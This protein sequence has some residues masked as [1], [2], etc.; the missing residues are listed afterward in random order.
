MKSKLTI[1]KL[2]P[3]P[4]SFPSF[5][6][7]GKTQKKNDSLRR[8]AHIFA[9]YAMTLHFP[10]DKTGTTAPELNWD[11]FV[12]YVSDLRANGT[13][14]SRT[15]L[16]WITVLA[17][18]FAPDV[19]DK[20]VV[21]EYRAR[22]RD[23]W[24]TAHFDPECLF[25]RPMKKKG[26]DDD[27]GNGGLSAG[28]LEAAQKAISEILSKH[29]SMNKL[30]LTL[31]K[32]TAEFCQKSELGV[33]AL[34]RDTASASRA[35]AFQAGSA[36]SIVDTHTMTDL[37]GIMRKLLESKAPEITPPQ[38]AAPQALGDDRNDGG[39]PRSKAESLNEGQAV[40]YEIAVEAIDAVVVWIEKG[41]RGYRPEAK[42]IFVHGGPGAG[43]SFL[44]S[45]ID[46]YAQSRG[47]HHTKMA[48]MASAANII[49]GR[50]IHSCAG[51]GIGKST[52]EN[53]ER[54]W[55]PL[56]ELNKTGTIW[57]LILDELS[58]L[59]AIMFYDA[60]MSYRKIMKC[61]R[62]FGGLSLFFIGDFFQIPPTGN[63][64]LTLFDAVIKVEV[65]GDVTKDKRVNHTARIFKNFRKVDLDGNERA[66]EDPAWA[67]L[68]MSLR[69]PT[70]GASPLGDYLIPIIDS[71]VLTSKDIEN[72]VKWAS[73]PICVCGNR[74]RMAL[75]KTRAR[76][77]AK[78][79][80][81]PLIRWRLRLTGSQVESLSTEEHEGIF[82]EDPCSWGFFIQGYA[83][84]F[85][86]KCQAR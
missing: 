37:K 41:M 7:S 68:I 57:G 65:H 12:T 21:M 54:D 3:S 50:T 36:P 34:F 64:A 69:D 42:H 66:K 8:Q 85:E 11:A 5:S 76:A 31:F 32:N 86:Q 6:K 56:R 58:M 61:D 74:Q 33:Q 43:K 15:I 9:Q 47:V 59:D 80:G 78:E 26:G 81:V 24:S 38:P 13:V 17:A 46:E 71:M 30:A 22:D 35:S 83:G 60:D 45:A 14:I 48:F 82:T 1:P 73:A 16:H 55:G 75:I 70:P 19:D 53:A 84:Y 49:G 79:L 4:P 51:F 62:P 40:V 18:G 39:T 23:L 2:A 52:H 63:K 25:H 67:S 72:D 77:I 28:R 44:V 20:I 27:G 29:S 10:W